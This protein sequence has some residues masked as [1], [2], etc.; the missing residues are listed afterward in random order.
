M[1]PRNQAGTAER[2][3][4]VGRTLYAVPTRTLAPT[5]AV[6]EPTP[7]LAINPA[8]WDAQISVW[9]DQPPYIPAA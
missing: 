5:P 6:N 9:W 8:G 7:E 3:K 2:N 4:V 1:E